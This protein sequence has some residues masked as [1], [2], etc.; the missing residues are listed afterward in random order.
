MAEKVKI[1]F[2]GD[3][4]IKNLPTTTGIL[5]S[6]LQDRIRQSSFVSCNFEGALQTPSAL[7]IQKAGPP[8]YQHPKAAEIVKKSGFNVV[9]LAN[10]HIFDYGLDGF[11]T[12]LEELKGIHH[13]GAGE[14]LESAHRPI[15]LEHEGL[16]IGM[17][18]LAEWGFGAAET[19]GGYAWIHH[20]S[21][22]N[23]FTEIRRQ[24]DFLIVQVHA[25]VEEINLPL[26]E[27][28]AAYR[29]LIHMGADAVIGHHPHTPQGWEIFEGKPIFYSLGNFYFDMNSDDPYW[30]RG[31]AIEL[32]LEKEKPI[33]FEVIPIEKINSKVQICKDPQ[34]VSYLKNITDAL[35]AADYKNA[36][37]RTVLHLWETRYKSYYLAALGAPPTSWNLI[38][39][40]KFFLKLILCR[41]RT[42]TT[43]LLH[44]LKI[45]SHRW[46]VERALEVL[47]RS[48]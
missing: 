23:H 7:P 18:A 13:V 2:A 22:K 36:I 8:I 25:G 17:I 33:S 24:V 1:F 46:T 40:G 45:E 43:L 10:N 38:L 14:D 48:H 20:D 44:N 21:V 19:T 16:K 3:V 27:W 12:T 4:H 11:K 30:N 42:N 39:W 5:N 47:E 6:D 26:P 28:R 41:K 37:D 9:S 35:S 32:S 29:N 31:Y 15:I 34:F